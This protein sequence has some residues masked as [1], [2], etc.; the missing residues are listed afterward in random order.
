[1]D[2][3][4]KN[5]LEWALN[6]S[7]Q[8]RTPFA[9]KATFQESHSR[10]CCTSFPN[11]IPPLRNES[12]NRDQ[13]S[14]LQR[15]VEE[16]AQ[17]HNWNSQNSKP[18]ELNFGRTA[19]LNLMSC[20]P[21]ERY[22]AFG[23]NRQQGLKIMNKGLA[24]LQGPDHIIAERKRREKLNQRFIEL[25]SVIPSLKKIDKASILLKSLPIESVVLVKNS[26]V[27][28]EDGGLGCSS[29][30]TGPK[31][32]PEI[33]VRLLDRKIL[34]SIHCESFKG[35]LVKVLS[36]LEELNVTVTQAN[37]MPFS[38]S[39]SFITLTAQI[40]EG[41]NITADGVMRKLSSALHQLKRR[42]S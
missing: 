25:S 31:S 12:N 13:F 40:E 26:C 18:T 28:S 33:E 29:S 21:K 19:D 7:E 35:L 14:F 1:M 22:K 4:E 27:P 20:D 41:S 8:I 34:I 24:P 2:R 30:S 16:Q 11:I 3:K 6:S 9:N 23:M 36:E 17:N 15:T 5:K 39:T 32:L 38:S 42:N 10:D 37:F